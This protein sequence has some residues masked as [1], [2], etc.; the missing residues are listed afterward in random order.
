MNELQNIKPVKKKRKALRVL[1]ITLGVI[2]GLIA[3]F[4]ITVF[5]VNKIALR[6]E[7]SKIIPYGQTVTVDGDKKMNVLIRGAGEE[8]IVLLPGYGTAVPARDFEL[9]I[10]ELEK[11]YRVIAIEPLG[12]GLS[13]ETDKERT[14]A[15]IVD[16]THQALQQLGVDR[17]VLMGHSIAGLYALDYTKKYPDE[18][19]A[20]AG[21]DTS[22]PNQGGMDAIPATGMFTFLKE[23]GVLRLLT[24]LNADP[25]E[26][27]GY[28]P[29]MV[30][31]I[32]MITNRVSNNPTILNEMSHIPENFKSAKEAE[33]TFPASL[34][35]LLFVNTEDAE[36][37]DW[38]KLHEEQVAHAE[39][40]KMIEMS[41]GH[42]LHHKNS[43]QIASE[44]RSF[45]KDV[46]TINR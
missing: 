26:A 3:L 36:V 35:L 6:S 43:P 19:I 40:G 29:E 45:L 31:Q 17:Y 24:N 39:K 33:A 1:L 22:V 38:N 8:N 9:L 4:F 46:Q 37:Q 42:Y 7:A 21:I 13:D 34:P 15:N 10:R 2:V 30:N 18:V 11:D 32:R 12:Y 41:G 16:E 25:Y 23:S 27:L 20:Y 28:D 44:L 5:A 14:T